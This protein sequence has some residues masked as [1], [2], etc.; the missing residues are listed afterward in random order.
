MNVLVHHSEIILKRKNRSFFEKKLVEN[1][2]RVFKDSKVIKD[3]GRILCETKGKIEDFKKVFGIKFYA[4]VELASRNELFE[5]IKKILTKLN[6]KTIKPVT[7]R[8]DKTFELKSPEI[9]AKIGE[10]A[11]KLGIKTDY[12]NGKKLFLEITKKHCYIYTEKL[13]GYGG[14]PVSSSGKVL[15]LL[16]G[17]IDSPVAAWLAM[18]RGCRVDFLHF[19]TYKKNEEVLGTKIESLVKKLNEYQGSSK[20]YLIPYHIYQFENLNT[21]QNI[22]LI[23]FKNFIIKIASELCRR[24]KYKAIITGDSLGQVASQTLQNLITTSYEITSLILRPL[25]TYNKDEIIKLAEEI[26]LLKES[27]KNYKDCCSIIAKKASTHSKIKQLKNALEKT[28]MNKIVK[29]SLK[30]MSVIQ[31]K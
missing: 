2:K 22:D 27:I 13:L 21:K 3:S 19:H 8:A 29:N 17:G 9:N 12:K 6:W 20:L 28:D 26:N 31:I 1:I 23:L 4:P 16:S 10:I 7:K 15:C 5:K 30:N 14:L 11:N 25:I 24:K 18:K